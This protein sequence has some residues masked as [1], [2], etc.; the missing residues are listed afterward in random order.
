MGMQ[1]QWYK[2]SR[3]FFLE[4]FV[5]LAV[6]AFVKPLHHHLFSYRGFEILSLLFITSSFFIFALSG[7]SIKIQSKIWIPTILF[8]TYML[9]RHLMFE[10]SEL[11]FYNGAMDVVY[12][13][14]IMITA[15]V[16]AIFLGSMELE[17]SRK[18]HLF[19]RIKRAILLLLIIYLFANCGKFLMNLISLSHG[20]HLAV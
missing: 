7:C 18:K 19:L 1:I 10:D 8:S 9:A 6:L 3:E 16:C 17:N 2:D 14:L 12:H 20:H 5:V 13:P 4:L 11:D 15:F